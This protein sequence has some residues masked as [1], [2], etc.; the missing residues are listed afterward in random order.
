MTQLEIAIAAL[1]RI[2]EDAPDEEPEREDYH[3]MESAFDNGMDV[4]NYECAAIALK[5]LK[6][7][8]VE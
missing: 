1:K 5:A 7:M 2:A 6:K 4:A 3:D 8:G